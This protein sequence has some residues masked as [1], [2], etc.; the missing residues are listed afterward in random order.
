MSPQ[1][2]ICIFVTGGMDIEGFAGC[3]IHDD[4]IR[5]WLDAVMDHI[6]TEKLSVRRRDGEAAW[7]SYAEDFVPD[8]C[9]SS[10]ELAPDWKADPPKV[11]DHLADQISRG[12]HRTAYGAAVLHGT[13][14]DVYFQ[15]DD[16][17]IPTGRYRADHAFALGCYPGAVYGSPDAEAYIRQHIL[18]LYPDTMK[19]GARVKAIKAAI[20]ES[21]PRQDGKWPHWRALSQWPCGAD[22]LP[23]TFSHQ[24]K[25]QDGW[26]E[27]VFHTVDGSETRVIRQ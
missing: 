17:A 1:E 12:M 4:A 22:G 26:M 20:G 7:R 6:I 10:K 16:T 13:V 27:Y 18:P 8:L 19:K 11:G 2:I 15:A 3:F 23:M 14:S 9:Q 25:A 5:S 24:K 21:F